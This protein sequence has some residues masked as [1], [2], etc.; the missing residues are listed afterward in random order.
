MALGGLKQ[1]RYQRVL[2]HN[3]NFDRMLASLSPFGVR[4]SEADH[5][6]QGSQRG[7]GGQGG[8]GV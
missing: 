7:P 2:K 1:E 6:L 8:P 3:C 5:G 4:C